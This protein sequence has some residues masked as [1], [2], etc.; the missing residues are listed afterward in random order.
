MVQ[1]VALI[2]LHPTQ[3]TVGMREVARRMAGYLALGVHQQR[4]LHRRADRPVCAWACPD[5]SISSIGIICAGRSWMLALRRVAYS[6]S[7]ISAPAARRFL[8]PHGSAPAGRIPSMPMASAAL[9][10][11][12]P[13]RSEHLA[14]DPYRALASVLRREKGY[15]KAD[16]P[17]EEFAWANFLRP[18]I[19]AE[20]VRADF[21]DGQRSSQSPRALSRS[22]HLPGWIG[23]P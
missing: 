2:D 1:N 11:R 7:R 14:D 16:L 17:F 15:A 3:M 10:R 21:T 19:S 23:N 4:G 12:S 18:R 9:R 6:W 5:D 22:P 20:L 13:P 8:A